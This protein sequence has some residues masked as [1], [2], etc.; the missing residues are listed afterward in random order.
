M[1]L[2]RNNLD[3]CV[4]P[5]RICLSHRA[6]KHNFHGI[7]LRSIIYQYRPLWQ[8]VG[9]KCN[10]H[11]Q[12]LRK[13]NASC[14][15]FRNVPS[16][17]HKIANLH[18][19]MTDPVK[20]NK[21]VTH[22]FWHHESLLLSIRGKLL[23]KI[24]HKYSFRENLYNK[25]IKTRLALS[26]RT[27]WYFIFCGLFGDKNIL[28]LPSVGRFLWYGNSKCVFSHTGLSQQLSLGNKILSML[29]SLGL[30]DFFRKNA[31]LRNPNCCRGA[32]LLLI[33]HLR[34]RLCLWYNSI[35]WEPKNSTVFKRCKIV[36]S[37][38]LVLN[39]RPK[40]KVLE[41]AWIQQTTDLSHKPINTQ[42]LITWSLNM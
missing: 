4:R 28:E 14:R 8:F 31:L 20:I 34:T 21:T 42:C 5:K 32:R 16:C 22:N 25:V 37:W 26:P 27:C 19:R 6:I 35:F 13:T 15:C 40:S 36:I 10:K 7:L 29:S 12:L 39:P 33:C 1:E 17:S 18:V 24:S 23:R 11:S 30:D 41:T 38:S 3:L 9:I 2:R